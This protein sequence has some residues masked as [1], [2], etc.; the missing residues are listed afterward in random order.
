MASNLVDTCTAVADLIFAPGMADG[1]KLHARESFSEPVE[2]V[3]QEGVRCAEIG[4]IVMK[5]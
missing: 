3:G 4:L 2:L 1:T 5:P